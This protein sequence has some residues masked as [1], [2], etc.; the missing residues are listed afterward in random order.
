MAD[1][2]KKM[3]EIHPRESHMQYID[4]HTVISYLHRFFKI[5]FLNT[6]VW[7]SFITVIVINLR[8]CLIQGWLL[9]NHLDFM[10][11]NSRLILKK[12]RVWFI[13][14]N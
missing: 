8:V 1:N 9:R 11:R 5:S 4:Q 7:K 14:Q 6:G 12:T 3:D 10:D 2:F 13:G